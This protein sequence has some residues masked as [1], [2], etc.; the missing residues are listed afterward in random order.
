V[1]KDLA[2]DKSTF[3]P[4]RGSPILHVITA[5]PT[6]GAEMMLFKLIS[7]TRGEW[8]Q[9]VVSLGKIGRIGRL[10]SDLGVPVYP[11]DYGGLVPKP[12]RLF[13]LISLVRRLRPRLMVGWLYHGNAAA[14]LAAS[15]CGGSIPVVWNIR[16]SLYDL[17]VEDWTTAKLIRLSARLSRKAEAVIYNSQISAPQHEALGYCA[18][19]RVVIPN[20]FDCRQ[21]LPDADARQRIRAELGLPEDAIVV[22]LTARYHPMKDHRNFFQAAGMIAQRYPSARFL[23][24]GSGTTNQEPGLRK[25]IAE[26]QLANRVLLLGDRADM[27]ALTASLDIACS[28]SAWGEGLSNAVGEAMAC[29]VPCVVTDV[30]DSARLVGETGVIVPAKDSQALANAFSRLIE[31]GPSGRRRLGDAARLRI[32]TEF[33]LDRV[34]QRY[35]EVYQEHIT[36]NR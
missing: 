36:N 13:G 23:L 15:V 17:E 30:G 22:G 21:F 24:V 27:P 18:V 31:A 8:P 7:A 19:N 29:G 32:E 9:V 5:L 28:A 12:L 20:G 25:L 10:I 11:V 6:G 3:I 14:S 2:S 1:S 35:I 16:Q 33:S 26:H 4:G 34:A